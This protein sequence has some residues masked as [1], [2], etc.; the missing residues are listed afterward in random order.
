MSGSAQASWKWWSTTSTQAPTTFWTG[1]NAARFGHQARSQLSPR[2]LGACSGGRLLTKWPL[3]MENAE[4]SD[5]R[6]T[7]DMSAHHPHQPA[8]LYQD[9]ASYSRSGHKRI[10]PGALCLI[11][12]NSGQA[13]D[14]PLSVYPDYIGPV[15]ER[16]QFSTYKPMQ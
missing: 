8:S 1:E 2:R 16:R 15:Y 4:T 3:T 11:L 7:N 12:F 13:C 5:R 14:L 10:D 9:R 6:L